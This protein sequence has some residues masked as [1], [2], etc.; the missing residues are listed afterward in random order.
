MRAA[1]LPTPLLILAGCVT[2][3][4]SVGTDAI[5][6]S[7]FEPI[8]WSNKDTDDTIRRAKEHNAAWAVIC[9]PKSTSHHP[10]TTER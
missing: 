5:A 3:T 6:S 7:A 8:R 4:A 9:H 1:L 2:T 10:T